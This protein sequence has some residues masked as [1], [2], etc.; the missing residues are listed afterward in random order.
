MLSI[1]PRHA[2][3]IE[4]TRGAG[5]LAGWPSVLESAGRRAVGIAHRRHFRIGDDHRLV[6]VPHSEV[7]PR[8][9]PAGLSQM[10]G[11]GSRSSP[12]TRPTPSSVS[13]SLSR[14]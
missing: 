13:A 1:S 2:A 12:I 7:A 14:V 9:M 10:T 3:G 8:S 6:G 5:M 4:R 11:R